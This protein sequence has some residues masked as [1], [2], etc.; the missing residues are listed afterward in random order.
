MTRPYGASRPCDAPVADP[1]LTSGSRAAA[2]VPAGRGGSE[3][4]N[5]PRVWPVTS[6]ARTAG[7]SPPAVDASAMNGE[8]AP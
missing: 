6:R 8:V 4:A 7:P 2:G 3:R 5:P 1:E